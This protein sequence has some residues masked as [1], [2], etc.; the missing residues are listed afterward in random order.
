MRSS[1]IRLAG[2]SLTSFAMSLT[3]TITLVRV[4][5][6]AKLVR[7]VPAKRIGLD[8]I[9]ELFQTC[10]T[11]EASA[12]WIDRIAQ[13]PV[14]YSPYREILDAIA[15]EQKEMKE[16]TVKYSNVQT[17]LRLKKKIVL[18]EQELIEL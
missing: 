3:R 8:R 5:D 4:K 17:H 10:I 1:P 12:A 16:D 11:P 15:A 14:V 9:R 18:S 6:M 7:L 2:T 13:E